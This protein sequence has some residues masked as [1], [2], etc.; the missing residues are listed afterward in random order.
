MSIFPDDERSSF[1]QGRPWITWSGEG[2]CAQTHITDCLSLYVSLVHSPTCPTK[3]R[4]NTSCSLYFDTGKALTKWSSFCFVFFFCACEKFKQLLSFSDW[5]VRCFT[6]NANETKKIKMKKG[7]DFWYSAVL[8][9]SFHWTN[10]T[11][12][13]KEKKP[14]AEKCN[15]I[16]KS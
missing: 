14:H 12:S 4:Q 15:W 1:I 8:E 2:P 16:K 7:R 13:H 5:A 11:E 3:L 10:T 9:V 6:M